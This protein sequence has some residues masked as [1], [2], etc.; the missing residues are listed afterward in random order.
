MGDEVKQ[1][2]NQALWWS[3]KAA[4]QNNPE[5]HYSLAGR[6]IGNYQSAVFGFLTG[7]GGET[8]A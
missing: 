3:R 7:K 2:F 8:P 1:N 4:E 6:F 5:G